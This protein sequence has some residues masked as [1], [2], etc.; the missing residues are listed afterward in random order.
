MALR[1]FG[2]IVT[3]GALDPKHHRMVMASGRF[4]MIA[5]GVSQPS[6]GP[7]IARELVDDGVQL[8][9]LCGGFG[10]VWTAR[11]IEAIG[12]S[13]PVGSVGYGPEA[14]APMQALFND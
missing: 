10:P 14:I 3:G 5:V 12:G 7:A 4:E 11:V 2:F 8:L 13:I 9:E 6:D 1:K